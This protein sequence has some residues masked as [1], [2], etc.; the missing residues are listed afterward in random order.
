LVFKSR[1]NRVELKK[2]KGEY[3]FVSKGINNCSSVTFFCI[4]RITNTGSTVKLLLVSTEHSFNQRE[5]M[6]LE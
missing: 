4:R 5:Y 6:N 2:T 3:G 1:V